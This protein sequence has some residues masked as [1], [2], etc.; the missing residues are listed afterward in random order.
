MSSATRPKLKSFNRIAMEVIKIEGGKQS[1]NIA[2]V[3]EMVG[4]MC[5][6]AVESPEMIATLILH[7]QYRANLRQKGKK[8]L[9]DIEPKPEHNGCGDC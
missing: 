6:L 3:N 7:G 4:I 8:L 2:Q 1:V 9:T 5:D